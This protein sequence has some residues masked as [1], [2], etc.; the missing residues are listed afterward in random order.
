[1]HKQTEV[2]TSF[3]LD[4]LAFEQSIGEKIS[5]VIF[6]ASMLL[7]GIIQAF[8]LG[9]ILALVVVGYMPLIIMGWTIN[10]RVRHQTFKEQRDIFEESDQRAQESFSAIKLVKQMNAE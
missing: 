9:W 4:T 10:V 2:T 5:T 7:T 3:S 6:L 8:V 1:M